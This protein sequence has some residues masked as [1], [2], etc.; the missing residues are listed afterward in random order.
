[1][2]LIPF[3]PPYIT[4]IDNCS[5]VP[6]LVSCSQPPSPLSVVFPSLENQHEIAVLIITHSGVL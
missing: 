3:P 6:L 5:G 2:V 1:M 4:R